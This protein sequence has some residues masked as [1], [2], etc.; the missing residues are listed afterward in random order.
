MWHGQQAFKVWLLGMPSIR[1]WTTWHGQRA[2][3]VERQSGC[4]DFTLAV[5]F[6]KLKFVVAVLQY[7]H[8]LKSQTGRLNYYSCCKSEDRPTASWEDARS[9][10]NVDNVTWQAILQISLFWHVLIRAWTMWH[11]KLD[12][13]WGF[14]SEPGQGD[15]T[16]RPLNFDF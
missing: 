11:S 8:L 14:R 4:L 9:A 5:V 6:F 12:F 7:V 10:Q 1:P 13:W 15:M 16:N 3:K 2:F